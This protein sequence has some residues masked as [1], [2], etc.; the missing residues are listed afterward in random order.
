[1]PSQTSLAKPPGFWSRLYRRL[2]L[3]LDRFI[4][5]SNLKWV[6]EDIDLLLLNNTDGSMSWEIQDAIRVQREMRAELAAINAE[7][8]Q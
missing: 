8:A 3:R 7:L 6:A 4:L 1:M 2:T 5:V